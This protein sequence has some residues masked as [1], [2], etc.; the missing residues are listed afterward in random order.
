[1]L[2][3]TSKTCPALSAVQS[4]NTGRENREKSIEH[5]NGEWNKAA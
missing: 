3:G 4:R 2:S 1:M 5:K